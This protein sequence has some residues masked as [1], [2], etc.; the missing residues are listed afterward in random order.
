MPAGL[1]DKQRRVP[2]RRNMFGDFGQVQVHGLCVAARQDK[3]G[4]LALFG[5]DRAEDI[6]GG[7]AL[8]LRRRGARTALGPAASYLVLLTDA[9]FVGEPDFDVAD[10]DA[11]LLGDLFQARGEV[12]LNASIAPSACA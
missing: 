9:G 7:G 8:V 11:L 12:F 4:A 10:F 1:I 5:T 3:P 6:G 2:A